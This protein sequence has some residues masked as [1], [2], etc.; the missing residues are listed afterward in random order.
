[1]IMKGA[2]CLIILNWRTRWRF[3]GSIW[4]ISPSALSWSIPA[5]AKFQLQTFV[6]K[7]CD[8]LNNKCS[9]YTAVSQA[10]RVL[11]VAFRGTKST[12]QLIDDL[13]VIATTPLQNFLNGK[14]QAYIFQ[15]GLWR[16]MAVH[17]AESESSRFKKSVLSDLGSRTFSCCCLSILGECM[18]CLLQY[19]STSKYNLLVKS[20]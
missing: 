8:F 18:A 4:S 9:G 12:R 15:H 14:V 16:F 10:L 2:W 5:S 11:V 6:T 17:R 7:N 20:N 1:M 19:R 13:L 3:F